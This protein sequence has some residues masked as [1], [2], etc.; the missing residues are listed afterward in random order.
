MAQEISIHR[1]LHHEFIVKFNSYFE[2]D[3]NVYIVLEL[4]TKKSLMEMQKRR[5]NLCEIEVRYFLRQI[6]MAIDY[7]HSD[8]IIHRDLKL[9]NIFI[10]EDMKLKV[11]D[12]GLATTLEFLGERKKTLCG[13]PNYIA[14]EVLNKKGHSFEVDIWSAGCILYTLMVGRPPF[15]TASL[16]ETYMKIR[17]GEYVIPQ[18][19]ISPAMKILLQRMLLIDPALRPSAKEILNSEYMTKAYI[20]RMI[21]VS[22]LSVAPRFDYKEKSS[23]DAVVG[24][25]RPLFE[26][27]PKSPVA[28][29]GG[30]GPAGVVLAQGKVCET[31]FAKAQAAKYMLDLRS[32][33]KSVIASNPRSKGERSNNNVEDPNCAPMLWIAKW[34]DYSDKYGFGYQLSDDSIGVSFNDMTKMILLPDGDTLHYIDKQAKEHYHKKSEYP[35][36]LAKKVKLLNYFQQYMTEN[37][38]KAGAHCTLGETA[39]M[40]RLPSMWTWFRTSRAVIMVLSNGTLQINNFEDHTKTILCPLM[41]AVTTLE[42][43]RPMR[44]FKFSAIETHGCSLG[45]FKK[46]EYALEKLNMVIQK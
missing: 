34:V 1:D 4:C 32:Q 16:K 44:T 8:K 38:L 45:L 10:S 22:A 5:R 42:H 29:S 7:L 6:L 41:G 19:K 37:L 17:R 27:N 35:L 30:G 11:G 21:P 43:N 24:A 13:T 31:T 28:S 14:P 2:D 33:I 18:I 20:P 40:T 36:E 26:H 12:F 46:I 3:N 9:G 23:G 39:A 15:E 25:K